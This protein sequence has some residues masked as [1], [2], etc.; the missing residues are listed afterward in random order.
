MDNE[1]I[2]ITTRD[3]TDILAASIFSRL[4]NQFYMDQLDFYNY[5]LNSQTKYELFIDRLISE[6]RNKGLL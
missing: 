4:Q 3:Q 1:K 6:L 2:D 5:I